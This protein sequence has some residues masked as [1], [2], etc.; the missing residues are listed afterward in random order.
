[1]AEL[2]SPPAQLATSVGG[3]TA[4][5]RSQDGEDDDGGVNAVKGLSL[6]DAVRLKQVREPKILC[7]RKVFRLRV[8]GLL[9]QKRATFLIDAPPPHSNFLRPFLGILLPPVR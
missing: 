9:P 3:F 4:P 1:M 7:N 6:G 8:G 2:P 5:A